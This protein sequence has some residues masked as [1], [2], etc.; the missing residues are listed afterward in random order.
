[1]ADA[2]ETQAVPDA[3]QQPQTDAQ[4]GADPGKETEQARTFTQADLDR[5]VTERL[6]K[7]K[8]RNE[9]AIKKAAEEAE[10]KAAEEQGKYQELYTKVQADLE[11][12]RQRAHAL[13]VAGIRRD[14][15]QRHNLPAALVDRLRGEDEATIEADAKELLKALPK[16][17]APDIN[18]GSGA[19]AQGAGGKSYLGGLSEQEF[20]VR[21][22]VRPDLLGKQ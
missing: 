12:E 3:E 4:T 18:A 5:I 2:V 19:V 8:A 10:R 6:G 17:A 1:M 15:A 21:F 13:E 16:P 11:A 9:A 14:V 7:E 22:G 20:A